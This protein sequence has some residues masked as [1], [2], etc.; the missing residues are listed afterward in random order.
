MNASVSPSGAVVAE[1]TGSFQPVQQQQSGDLLSPRGTNRTYGSVKLAPAGATNSMHAVIEISTTI[2]SSTLMRW[3]IAPG[4]C[5]ASSLPLLSVDQ[6]P[7]IDVSA[8]G[9]GKIAADLPVTMGSSGQYHVDVYWTTGTDR[10]DV[11]ACA[12]LKPTSH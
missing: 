4:R 9:Q 11:M 3:S 8:S 2:T 1:W 6:F 10:S 5:G 12:N 7:T